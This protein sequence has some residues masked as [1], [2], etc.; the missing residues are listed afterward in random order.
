MRRTATL[1]VLVLGVGCADGLDVEYSPPLD[2]GP[3]DARLDSGAADAPLMDQANEDE[4]DLVADL[5]V[6]SDAELDLS[7]VDTNVDGSV[8]DTDVDGSAVDTSIDGSAVDGDLGA[9]QRAD[10]VDLDPDADFV[11][12]QED[13][14]DPLDPD[15]RCV[16]QPSGRDAIEVPELL[17][18]GEEFEVQVRSANVYTNVELEVC[19]AQGAVPAQ[20]SGVRGTYIWDFVVPA[21]SPGRVVF[22]FRTDPDR[23]ARA[24]RWGVIQPDE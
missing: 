19:T 11:D 9:D 13:P 3:A 6:P 22:V 10:S 8:V 18:A 20:F 15:P 21:L 23:T 14:G 17:R 5:E 7:A 24:A 4:P 12:A 2:V 1:L 16:E